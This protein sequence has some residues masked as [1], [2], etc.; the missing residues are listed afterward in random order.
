MP[1][2]TSLSLLLTSLSFSFLFS[3]SGVSAAKDSEPQCNP[4][5]TQMEMNRCAKDDYVAA[6]KKLNATWKALLAKEKDNK[7]YIKS[8]RAAQRAW[9][10]FRDKEIEAMFACEGDKI[11]VCWGSM[12]PLLYHSEMTE[13]TEARTKRL[14][15]YLEQGQNDAAAAERSL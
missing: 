2:K 15:K 13:I 12:Y 8:L 10:K 9:I 1:N 6:D 4:E 11:R 3:L 5:G 14:Q 7:A